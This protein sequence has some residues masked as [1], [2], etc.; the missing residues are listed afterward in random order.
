MID[1][2]PLSTN[3]AQLVRLSPTKTCGCL[4][5]NQTPLRTTH[6][7]SWHNSRLSCHSPNSNN[8]PS[9]PPPPPPPP[10]HSTPLVSLCPASPT[11]PFHGSTLRPPTP[12]LP[13]RD[14][15][16]FHPSFLPP[17]ILAFMRRTKQ[18]DWLSQRV[19]RRYPLEKRRSHS[20][21]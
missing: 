4:Y 21:S 5:L 19:A 8:G 2:T 14:P 11:I 1:H 15:R 16:M 12:L 20:L 3:N 10:L 13:L 18:E 7:S 17:Y 6:G 9:A